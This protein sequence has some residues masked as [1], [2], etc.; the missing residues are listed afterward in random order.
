MKVL[1]FAQLQEVAGK[2]SADLAAD[3]VTA[4]GL[5]ALLLAQWP[6]LASH[7]VNVRLARNGVYAAAGEMFGAG[8]EV[9]LIPPV[10]GG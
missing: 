4:D 8:D 6:G 2:E 3:G 7:R 5:W 1:F 9:A 10:S